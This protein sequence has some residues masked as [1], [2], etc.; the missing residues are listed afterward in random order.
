MSFG[1][2]SLVY[3]VAE[4]EKKVEILMAERHYHAP[5]PSV[6]YTNYPKPYGCPQ[7]GQKPPTVCGN[8]ACPGAVKITC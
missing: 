4:L 1:I 6:V 2:E 5:I 3:R 7:C 8:V